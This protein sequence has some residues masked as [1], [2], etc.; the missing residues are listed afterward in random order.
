MTFISTNNPGQENALKSKIVFRDRK[1]HSRV[2]VHDHS[3][4]RALSEGAQWRGLRMEVGYNYGWDGEDLT[5][6]GNLVGINLNE[7]SLHLDVLYGEN[8]VQKIVV[9]GSFWIIPEDH[10]FSLHHRSK[11]YWASAIID[12]RVIAKILGQHYELHAGY[13]VVDHSLRHLFQALIAELNTTRDKPMLITKSIIQSFVVALAL[14]HGAPA[15]ESPHKGGLAPKQLKAITGWIEANFAKPITV[16]D[17]ASR[18]DLSV[19]YFSTEFKRS[20]GISPWEYVI[21]LRL[22]HARNLLKSGES[23]CSIA[24]HCGFFDQAHLAR[25]FKKRFGFSPSS[26]LEER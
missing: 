15:S 3:D 21:E 1:N 18:L 4:I 17:M 20:V 19:G 25:L 6:D 2:P 14:R 22:K 11:A 10:T 12:S 8:W 9:P 5:I 26:L 7:E 23:I 13:G 16:R 24:V